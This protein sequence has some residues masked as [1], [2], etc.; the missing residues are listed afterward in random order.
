MKQSLIQGITIW[1]TKKDDG[2]YT[3]PP[4]INVEG[5]EINVNKNVFSF[6]FIIIRVLTVLLNKV[7]YLWIYKL[8][9]FRGQFYWK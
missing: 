6:L 9:T 1:P 7:E 2:F 5:R 4:K 8:S 3:L